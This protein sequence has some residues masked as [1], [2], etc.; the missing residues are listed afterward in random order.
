MTDTQ[1]RIESKAVALVSSRPKVRRTLSGFPVC[2]FKVVTEEGPGRN[3]VVMPIYVFGGPGEAQRRLALECGCLKVGQLVQATGI[4]RQRAQRTKEGKRWPETA[5]EALDVL[6]LGGDG[7]PRER[8]AD[9]GEELMR[10]LVVHCM[11]SPYEVYIGRGKDPDT[12]EP[13]Q[14]G[15]R[16]SHRESSFE[17]VIHVDT[18]EEAVARYKTDLWERIRSGELSL[19]R[20][21]S[22]AGKTLGCWC[23][24]A[25]CH[26]DVL[27]RASV[28]AVQELARQRAAC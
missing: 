5:L 23:A 9:R 11:K 12:E 18:P 13:G 1:T 17:H 20:L 25:C 24:P 14:W 15:N 26:G 10:G 21:A 2:R 22:L 8:V 28:W 27:A 6:R 4:V 16:Y 7:L 19:E 3:P